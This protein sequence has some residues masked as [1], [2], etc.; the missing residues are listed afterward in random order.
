MMALKSSLI[1]H[2]ISL[3]PSGITLGSFL[4][5]ITATFICIHA[6]YGAWVS[7]TNSMGSS[8]IGGVGDMLPSELCLMLSSRF[9]SSS[10]FN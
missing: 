9:I 2:P 7:S 4:T 10:I 3:G 5:A 1:P 8:F 6:T